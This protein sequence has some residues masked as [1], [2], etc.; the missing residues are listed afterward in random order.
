MMSDAGDR[1]D[2][3]AAGSPASAPN[4]FG[5]TT[6]SMHQGLLPWMVQK[7][8]MGQAAGPNVAQQTVN[9]PVGGG[10]SGIQPHPGVLHPANKLKPNVTG[11]DQA[12]A[13]R[14]PAP[15]QSVGNHFAWPA[16]G[17]NY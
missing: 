13:L 9:Q 12:A 4:G 15:S 8:Q 16:P 7:Q 1:R 11:A 14:A 5:G 2:P 17:N 3:R 10:T 6:V